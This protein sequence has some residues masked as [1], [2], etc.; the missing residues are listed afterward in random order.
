[1]MLL[2][3]GGRIDTVSLLRAVSSLRLS[4]NRLECLV[5]DL[6]SIS[7]VFYELW[8]P[9][10]RLFV[11]FAPLITCL[12]VCLHVCVDDCLQIYKQRL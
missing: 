8:K 1:M 6:D 5:F 4:P 11:L 2:S 7:A 3:V 9:V 10:A 12:F